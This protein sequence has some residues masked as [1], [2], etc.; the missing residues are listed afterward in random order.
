MPLPRDPVPSLCPGNQAC[1]STTPTNTGSSLDGLGQNQINEL[2]QITIRSGLYNERVLAYINLPTINLNT[3][4]PESQNCLNNSLNNPL[5]TL[6]RYEFFYSDLSPVIGQLPVFNSPVSNAKDTPFRQVI[7]VIVPDGYQANTIRSAQ[8]VGASQFRTEPLQRVFNNPVINAE[9]DNFF[10]FN[11]GQAWQK[12]QKIPYL[13]LGSVPYSPTNNQLGVGVVYFMRNQDKT[14]LPSRPLP[15]FD[16]LPGDLLYSPIRQV[17][18]AIAENRA[19]TIIEDPSIQIQS[20]EDLLRAVN[21]GVFRL[22]D[23]GEFFN[24]PVYQ[25]DEQSRLNIYQLSLVSARHFPTLP[26]NNYYALWVTNQLNEARLLLRFKAHENTLEDLDN[27]TTLT[28]GPGSPSIFKFSPTEL[29]SFKHFL[30]T[31][32]QGNVIQPTGSTLLEARYEGRAE[33]DLKV[34]FAST[35]SALQTGNFI[36]AAPTA[37]ENNLNAS[38]IWF[39]Q[40]TDKNQTELPIPSALEPGLVMSLPPRGWVYNGW[41]L[42]DLRNPL[43][44]ETGRFRAIN[45][46]DL[47]S[48]YQDN[49]RNAYPFP[50]E[51]FL[52]RAPQSV[53]FPLDL[54]STGEREIVVSLEPEKLN[55]QGPFFAI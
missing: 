43:W 18:L 44:L 20:Q 48:R 6:V 38:G 45:Q 37:R 42:P 54:P 17:F 50:G 26:E 41:L 28:I 1:S 10:A 49:V 34:P 40:R 32:E 11:I 2:S 33:T 16:S 4:K 27:A 47:S 36:L 25:Q 7:R 9:K 15:I 53:F 31:I 23:T 21:Q 13:E 5:S 14:D 22:E 51:D 35:Y 12:D 19:N 24:Y 30:V 52:T 46:A 3:C 55:L 39:V 29:E 8:D